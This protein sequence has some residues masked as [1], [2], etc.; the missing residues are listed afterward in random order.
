MFRS[1]SRPKVLTVEVKVACLDTI[2]VVKGKW[3]T[4]LLDTAKKYSSLISS[5]F[6]PN[7][8]CASLKTRLAPN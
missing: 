3:C 6:P 7:R 2:I 1:Q 8:V 4:H 5:S